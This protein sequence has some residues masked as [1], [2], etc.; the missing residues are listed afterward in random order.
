MRIAGLNTPNPF[1]LA[2]M[3]GYTD[4]AFRRMCRRAGAGLCF[5][6]M[7]PAPALVRGA[8]G[9][10]ALLRFPED[11]HPV[12]A[13]VAGSDPECMAEAARLAEAA[14]ADAVDVNAGCP[15]RR[16]TNGGAGAA[17]LSDLP[18]LERILHAV[19][20]AIRVPL[21]LKVRLGPS[22]DR[23]VVPEI[24]RLATDCGVDAVT[25]HARTRVQRFSGNAD[26]SWIARLR[27]WA[28]V[29]VIGNGDVADAEDAL[30]MM[31]ETG[32]DGVMVGRAAVGSPWVFSRMLAA[33]EGRPIPAP[34]HGPERVGLIL[35]H[36]DALVALLDGDE[37]RAARIFRK[38]LVRY[39]RGLPGAVAVRRALVGLTDR[40]G[41]V[42]LLER[43]SEG[44]RTGEMGQSG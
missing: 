20:A 27:E 32:C 1:V 44:G 40:A 39:V 35:D 26:W 6:E 31:R 34:P 15:S 22:A 2:P 21:T 11:D 9:A 18:R 33:W 36:Y 24:A 5:T 30:R 14:G 12:V 41:L 38:H 23:V 3:D 10:E 4:A 29:P 28:T 37:A 8:K 42:A 13:Q 7:I 17:L 16:V 19:R 43:V 25:L